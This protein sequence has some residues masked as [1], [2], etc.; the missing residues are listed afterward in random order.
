[1]PVDVAGKLAG[2]N[3]DYSI[4][5]LYEAIEKKDYVCYHYH[6]MHRDS[7]SKMFNIILFCPFYF[8]KWWHNTVI[9]AN[10]FNFCTH[11]TIITLPVQPVCELQM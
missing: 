8:R 3:P 9:L 1:M 10:K 2:D 7:I 6:Y 11:V 4:E 5:D